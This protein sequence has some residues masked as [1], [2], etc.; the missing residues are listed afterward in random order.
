M[1]GSRKRRILFLAAAS[2]MLVAGAVGFYFVRVRRPRIPEPARPLTQ[3]SAT[4][5][6]RELIRDRMRATK[7]PGIVIALV[8]KE[9][10]IWAEGFGESERGTG[11]KIAADTLFSMQSISK[12][13]TA[14]AFLRAV[15][16]GLFKLDDRLVDT[17]PNF[18]VHSRVG[19]EEAQK[20]TYRHLLSHWSG[21]PHEAPVGNNFDYTNRS[22]DEHIRSISEVWLRN[23]PG[24]RYNYSNL[25]VDLVAYAIQ[26]RTGK[27]FGTYVEE[28]VFRPLGM[29]ASTF[30]QEK[31]WNSSSVAIGYFNDKPLQRAYIPMLGAGGMYTNAND[32]ARCLQMHLGGGIV[33]GK[34]FLTEQLLRE[35]YSLQ[36][37]FP[38]QRTGYGIGTIVSALHDATALNHGGGGF[39]CN[40]IQM[41]LP[42][43]GLGVV[44]FANS[45]T[46][47]AS[48]IAQRA[49]EIQYELRTGSA[50][51]TTELNPEK[52]IVALNVK[53]LRK[54]EGTYMPRGGLIQFSVRGDQLYFTAGDYT[55]KLRAHSAT[56]F[57]PQAPEDH[58][59][60]TFDIDAQ[61][62]PKGVIEAAD[63]I[64]AYLPLNDQPDDP[65]GPARP[66]WREYI[67]KYS[68]THHNSQQHVEISERN[69]YLYWNE[70]IRLTEFKPGL[71]FTCDGDSAQ[72]GVG[73]VIFA[74]VRWVKESG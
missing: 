19:A 73:Q 64:T 71:F 66:E 36:F 25:G 16:Q 7:T 49:L 11:R 68:I 63:F 74:N 10:V 15:Q 45:Q 46:A 35:M 48:Q 52:P 38:G 50:P 43:Y 22:F 5:Y 32:A 4:A 39:G 24:E 28:E 44:V 33:N 20:I 27:P 9:R 56:E 34:P 37:S 31:A 26:R 30:D 2:L 6:L 1:T 51:K 23:S 41:W 47:N 3:A 59:R 14:L 53:E 12:H 29:N 61:G 21:L 67:G 8:E 18:T 65:P 69:G 57:T 60:W 72:F 42:E 17:F 58:R 54:L 13:Y 70:K 62:K 40:T 55:V